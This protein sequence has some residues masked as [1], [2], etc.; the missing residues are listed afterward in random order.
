VEVREKALVSIGAGSPIKFTHL[1]SSLTMKIDAKFR[2][3]MMMRPKGYFN[4]TTTYVHTFKCVVPIY[5]SVTVGT[6]MMML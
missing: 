5:S 4:F 2:V 1:T 3:K 6:V